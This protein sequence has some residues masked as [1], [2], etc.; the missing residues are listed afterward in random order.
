MIFLNTF[1]NFSLFY[2]IVVN[3]FCKFLSYERSDLQIQ[4]GRRVLKKFDFFIELR[5]CQLKVHFLF[6][7]GNRL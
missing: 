1:V 5:M 4:R 2:L 3:F 6:K 7:K